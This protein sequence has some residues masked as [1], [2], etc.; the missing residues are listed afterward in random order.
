MAVGEL[1]DNVIDSAGITAVDGPVLGWMLTHRNPDTTTVMEVLTNLGS[2]VTMA[3][4]AVLVITALAWRRCGHDAVL[5]AAVALGA[6]VLV[7]FLKPLIGRVRPPAVDHLVL[8]T[9][10]SFPS[11][12]AVG[13][14]AVFGVLAV[15]ALRRTRRPVPRT[16]I[17]LTAAVAAAAIGL[18]RLYLGVHWASDVI[19]G[20]LIGALWLSVCLLASH[21]I[22]SAGHPEEPDRND[23]HP[24]RP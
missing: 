17:P 14:A 11:G 20:W 6:G 9:S 16:M 3:V 4:L 2:T 18:S 7:V 15:V 13:A 21:A 5:V 24:P 12:H 1:S 22:R 19:V 10:Q 8:E 23:A